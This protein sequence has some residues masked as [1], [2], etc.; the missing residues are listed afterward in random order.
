MRAG[1][2]LCVCS[3]C[4]YFYNYLEVLD[5]S[6]DVCALDTIVRTIYAHPL[7]QSHYRQNLFP[8]VGPSSAIAT[9]LPDD[10]GKKK[11]VVQVLLRTYHKRGSPGSL[12]GTWLFNNQHDE[13]SVWLV[14]SQWC[15]V[16]RYL[17][18]KMGLCDSFTFQSP[19]RRRRPNPRD[20]L[21]TLITLEIKIFHFLSCVLKLLKCSE[22]PHKDFL[23]QQQSTTSD[24]VFKME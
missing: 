8:A 16:V 22:L 14:S 7:H 15:Y 20:L 4:V 24:S 12:D 21:L 23:A 10:S 17:I 2:H 1:L 6:K 18:K 5:R 9:Y 11:L 3:V 13:K 19:A